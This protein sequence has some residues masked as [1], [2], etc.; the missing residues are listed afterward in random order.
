MRYS[1]LSRPGNALHGQK[2]LVAGW[3]DAAPRIPMCHVIG[4]GGNGP[5]DGLLSRKTARHTNVPCLRKK[6]GSASVMSSNTTISVEP[7]RSNVP[8]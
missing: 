5:G 6:R 8:C 7:A 1:V 4:G 2:K 3:R